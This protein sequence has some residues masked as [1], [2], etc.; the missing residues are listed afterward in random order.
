MTDSRIHLEVSYP[1]ID[2]P[3]PGKAIE[4]TDGVLWIRIPLPMVLDHINIWAIRED[5]GWAIV[6]AGLETRMIGEMWQEL[7]ADALGGLPVTRVIMTHMHPDHIGM[8]GW[9]TRRFDC[10]M[11]ITR[12]EYVTCRA[13]V[14]DTLREAPIDGIRFYR[15]AGWE[16][17][18]I[19]SY[20]MQFGDFG[21]FVHPLPDSFRRIQHREV[22]RIGA[23]DWTV[24]VGSGH[25]PEHASFYCPALKLFISGDQVLPRISSNVSVFPTEPDADPLSDWLKSLAG[26]SDAVADNVLALPSHKLPFY[27]LHQRVGELIAEHH[28]GLEK[29]TQAIATPKRAVDVFESLFH[30][31][32]VGS[33]LLSMATGESIAH[34]NYLLNHGVAVRR[35]DDK[36][37]A[38]YQK[39]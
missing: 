19:D 6:D 9:L 34:L 37:V 8:A 23:H 33:D 39:K 26:V 24:V 31:R 29:L 4:I 14:G 18:A 35:F 28:E 25:S 32:I 1:F 10:R 17:D 3:E 13:L 15:A 20:R 5:R 12:L 27:G 30:T 7:L 38:W 16:E 2:L 11:W 21:K 22:M 36:G